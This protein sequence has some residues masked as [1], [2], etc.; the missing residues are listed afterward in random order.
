M[1]QSISLVTLV[2]PDYDEAIAYYV[3]KLGFDLLEDTPLND[4]K[5]WVCVAPADG[6][7]A[8]LLARAEGP[9]QAAI[10]GNQTGGRVGFFL[11]TDDFARD[12]AAMVHAGVEFLEVPREEVYGMVAIF[13][14][15]FGN[16]W[17]LIERK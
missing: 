2:V 5:R 15:P 11:T 3:G 10:V 13:R 17:D 8:L 16:K 7:T 4:G 9:Q 6:G 1:P 12:Y 14:D